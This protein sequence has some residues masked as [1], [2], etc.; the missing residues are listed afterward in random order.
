MD[1][2]A[3]RFGGGRERGAGAGG[4]ALDYRNDK[5]EWSGALLL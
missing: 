3:R 5:W 4:F 2:A 1:V